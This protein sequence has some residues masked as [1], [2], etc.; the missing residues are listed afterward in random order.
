VE[1]A[2]RFAAIYE[3]L[4]QDVQ[5]A[6]DRVHS[7][8]GAKRYWAWHHMLLAVANFKAQMPLF[9]KRLPHLQA[10]GDLDRRDALRVPVPGEPLT[11]RSED[12]RTWRELADHISGLGVSRT[13]TALSALWPG[14]HVIIDWRAASAAAALTGARHGWSLVPVRPDRHDPLRVDWKPT[15]GIA[16]QSS[17]ALHRRTCTRCG[18]NV[19]FTNSATQ[20]RALPGRTTLRRSRDDSP[21]D[22]NR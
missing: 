18:S 3:T 12:P 20:C 4:W 15:T 9:P 13:T 8:A 5:A 6:A 22:A 11:L 14:R 21:A 2:G 10:D 17:T 16:R 7:T 1:A 19:R